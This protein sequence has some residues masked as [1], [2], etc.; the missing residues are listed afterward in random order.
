MDE[1]RQAERLSI[2]IPIELRNGSGIT[3][4]VS[5][6]GVFF[7]GPFPF[8]KDEQVDF[9]LRVPGAIDVQCSGRVVRSEYDREAM[10]YG[11]AVTIDTFDV[12]GTDF[13]E[14]T[15]SHIVLRE[16]IKHHEK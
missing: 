4:D 7:T 16:L 6:L 12:S 10:A 1:R 2:S 14:A 13:S 5:G 3:R 9:V 8:E 15:E 11:V